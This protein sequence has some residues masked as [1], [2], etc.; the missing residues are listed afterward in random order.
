MVIAVPLVVAVMLPGCG[1]Q[2]VSPSTTASAGAGVIHQRTAKRR[3]H[4]PP[5][6]RPALAPRPAALPVSHAS[7]TVVQPQPDDGSCH[8]TGSG[9][10]SQPDPSCTPGALNP[11]VTQATIGQTICVSGYSKSVRPP[12]SIT[13]K[14]KLASMAAYGD[15]GSPSDFE[16]DH[17]VSLELGGAPNDPRNLWPE[18]GASPNPKDSIENTLHRLVCSRQMPLGQAQKI[19][20][21]GWI[22]YF[23]SHDAG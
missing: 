6:R 15:S 18:P 10:F 7:S 20:A 9:K 16:Y 21:T 4:H 13:N 17:L 14:E 22:A 23:R 12:E 3:R 19:I 5:A 1:A 2:S 11:A 8:P